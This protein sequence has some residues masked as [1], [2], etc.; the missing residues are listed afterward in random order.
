VRELSPADLLLGTADDQAVL[1]AITSLQIIPRLRSNPKE[2]RAAHVQISEGWIETGQEDF[3]AHFRIA[4]SESLRRRSHV[5]EAKRAQFVERLKRMARE[6][7]ENRYL[8]SDRARSSAPR[9]M[10]GAIEGIDFVEGTLARRICSPQLIS[11]SCPPRNCS[12]DSRPCAQDLR[13]AERHRAQIDFSE[14]GEGDWL[15]I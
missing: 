4:R 9:N 7:R 12:D 10:A 5:A 11:S 13:R 8:F 6:Q 2:L 3:A 1:S 15:C 14:L